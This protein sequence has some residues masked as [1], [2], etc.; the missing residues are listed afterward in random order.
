[1]GLTENRNL[2]KGIGQRRIRREWKDEETTKKGKEQEENRPEG[3]KER[4]I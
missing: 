2:P 1:L 3:S 4:E